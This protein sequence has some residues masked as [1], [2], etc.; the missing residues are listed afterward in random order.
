[1]TDLPPPAVRFP[2]P[3]V[4]VGFILLGFAADRFFLLPSIEASLVMRSVAGG[5]LILIGLTVIIMGILQFKKQDEN[6][7]PWTGSD[8]V[9]LEGIYKATRNPMYLGMT[10]FSLG[11]G[12]AFGS[13]TIIAFAILSAIIIDRAVI[14]KEEVYLEKRFGDGYL[15]YK[16]SVRRWI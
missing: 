5:L 16:N 15:K 13:F 4:F 9:V 3:L 14:V 7:E 1:M 6:P 8:T 12:I 11:I 2:P 10:L